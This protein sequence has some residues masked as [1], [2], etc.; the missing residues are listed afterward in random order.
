M[1]TDGDPGCLDYIWLRGPLQ[2]RGLPARLR[3]TG[4]GRSNALPVGSPRA[5]SPAWRSATDGWPVPFASPIAATGG[6]RRRTRSPR[7]A[8]RSR[9]TRCDGLEFDV[10][11]SREGTPIRPPRRDAGPGPGPA[12]PAGGALDRRHW[13]RPG[14]RPSPTSSRRPDR[15]PFLDVELK[16]EPVPAVIPV[17][18][19]ARGT[20]LARTVV[21]SFEPETL[22]WLLGQRPGWPCWL[23]VIDLAPRSLEL[24]AGWGA[25]GCRSTGPRSTRPGWPGRR[26]SGWRSQP[27]R[28]AAGRPRHASSGS[29]SWRSA[30]RRPPS[31]V[32][33]G[34]VQDQAGGSFPRAG[35]AI[36]PAS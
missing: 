32:E 7:C 20:A 11:G 29:G 13:S 23:N 4:G 16:G 27:G 25:A 36:V 28:S 1:D 26:R 35:Q 8:P 22:A 21:S 33:L 34:A 30:W 9:T 31:T 15:G 3:P 18:E 17:L 14:S 5:R 24:A 2:R 12:R 19:A 6:S 10:R